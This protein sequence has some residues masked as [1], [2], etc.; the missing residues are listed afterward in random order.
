MGRFDELIGPLRAK[1]EAVTPH[2]DE[3]QRRLLYGA[4]ARILGHGG[5]AAV[6]KAAGVS[7][8]CV[9]RGLAE[10]EED[11]APHGRTRRAGAGRPAAAEKDPGLRAAL[12]A[13][14]ED[15]T[16]GD[17]IRPLT[18]TTKSLRHLAGELAAQ[19][20]AV[21]RDTIAAL[22]K[23]AGFS[24]RANARVLAGSSHP[25]RDAQ[26]RHLN[27]TVGRFLAAGD[28]VISVDTKKKEQIGLFAQA[29]R[30]WVPPGAPVKVLDHDFPSHATGTAIPYGIYDLGRNT[31]FVVVGTDHDTAAFAVAALRRWW[32]EEGQ[33]AYP[34]AHRLLITADGGGSNSSRARAWKA[35]LAALATETGLEISVCHLPPGTSK[36][37][38]VEHRLFSFI[39]MN[40]R[41]R[42]LT[43]YEVAL[44]LIA[45]T[46]TT[47]GLRVSARLDEGAYPTGIEIDAQHLAA[48]RID[49]DDF[50]GEWNY[51]I[52][53][54]PGAPAVPLQPQGRRAHPRQAHTFDAALATHPVLTGLTRQALDQL[55]SRVRELIDQLAPGQRPRH[56]KLAVENIIW[57]SV[58]DQRGLPASLIA[59]LFRVGENQMR[60][61]LQQTRPLLQRHGHH[62]DPLPV[63]LI[64]P[65][66]LARYVIHATTTDD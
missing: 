34:D 41:A 6:A 40:W 33:T 44:N 65:S 66:E 30:E 20:H 54:Q 61:L 21:G 56:R 17:P 15:S 4:E 11:P 64:D 18:W 49:P 31:G 62:S 23:Q 7:K 58:L 19:G 22:L 28:P 14:V 51:T 3:R 5:I 36:W 50:H 47:T 43:S 25:D 48:L 52:P 38:K 57:A 42:P 29:G 12:L 24:L 9:S 16:Q 27:D 2:L 37:N 10:L 53:P 32:R 26:F 59:H 13:L 39:S 1:L 8:G 63:R 55:V 35:N 60:T 46:T 45:S